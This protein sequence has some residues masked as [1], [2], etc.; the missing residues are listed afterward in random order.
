MHDTLYLRVHRAKLETLAAAVASGA[1]HGDIASP[2][3]LDVKAEE[4]FVAGQACRRHSERCHLDDS[5]ALDAVDADDP[6]VD[7]GHF[8]CACG[9][10]RFAEVLVGCQLESG[11]ADLAQPRLGAG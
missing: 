11:F 10:L 7:G 5:G 2:E 1:S 6:S 9:L 4:I 8:A 3:A